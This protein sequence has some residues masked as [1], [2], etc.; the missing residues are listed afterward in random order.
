VGTTRLSGD[1]RAILGDE[2]DR[3]RQIVA[4]VS[5]AEIG[6][7]T[8][9]EGWRVAD[10]L[11]HLR[12]GTEELLRGWAMPSDDPADRDYV[13]Y[14]QDWPAH[15]PPSF[16]DLRWIWAN[17][18]SYATA[19][20]LRRH[21]D[22]VLAAGAAVSRQ[23]PGGRLRFQ[24][25]VLAADDLLAMFAVEFAIHHLDLLVAL[26]D[27]PGPVPAALDLAANTLD[28]LLGGQHPASWDEP[29]Y[30]RKGTG[31]APLDAADLAELGAA[32]SRYPAFG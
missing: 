11:V 28:G 16:A 1:V 14:W 32:A 26:P 30:L 3:L 17:S 19:A 13:T 9:C 23:A 24:G 25:H 20:S 7:A 18:A 21:F 15:G 10:L 22:D 4:G 8:G 5:D 29:T 31:R 2:L 12:L 27:R 6:R